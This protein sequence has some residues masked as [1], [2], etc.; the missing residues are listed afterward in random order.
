[1]KAGRPGSSAPTQE[2]AALGNTTRKVDTDAAEAARQRRRQRYRLQEAAAEL[3][4]GERRLRACCKVIPWHRERLAITETAEGDARYASLVRCG[5]WVQCPIC[6]SGICAA[7]AI[8]LSLGV[9]TWLATGGSVWL[10]TLTARHGRND[11]LRAWLRAFTAAE[12][13][14]KQGRIWRR[15][16]E[17]DV[18]AGTVRALEVTHGL[19]AG[20]HPHVHLMLFCCALRHDLLL[21]RLGF[22][23]TAWRQA[24]AAKASWTVATPSIRRLE[25]AGAQSACCASAAGTA[26]AVSTLNCRLIWT[27]R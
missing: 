9:A 2:L 8:E 21:I 12:K 26:F 18:L 4:P 27:A 25:N 6:A 14:M 10:L 3:R 19:Q 7:R 15:L 20:W 11:D 22:L 1:M 5:S 23:E 16:R 17:D 13:R 24:N